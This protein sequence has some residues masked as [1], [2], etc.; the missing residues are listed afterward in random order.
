L[1]LLIKLLHKFE[2][3]LLDVLPAGKEQLLVNGEQFSSDDV[4]VI[5]KGLLLQLELGLLLLHEFFELIQ[6]SLLDLSQDSCRDNLQLVH[7]LR[8]TSLKVVDLLV[9][10]ETICPALIDE[11]VRLSEPIEASDAGLNELIQ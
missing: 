8:V 6:G 2:P 1:K 4:E 10:L 3:L 11:R 9:I 7:D 5:N